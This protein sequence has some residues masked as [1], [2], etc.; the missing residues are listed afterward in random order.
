M[1]IIKW[2]EQ[3]EIFNYYPKILFFS[4]YEKARDYKSELE[5]ILEKQSEDMV[6]I[7]KNKILSEIYLEEINSKNIIN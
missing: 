4:K 5:M 3:D 7:Y 6:L 2:V 1:F